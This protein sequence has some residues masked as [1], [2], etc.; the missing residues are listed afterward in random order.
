MST[1]TTAPTVPDMVREAP[2]PAVPVPTP[3]APA[4]A[5][6]APIQ[7][8]PVQVPP[9]R[10]ANA[11]QVQSRAG[12]G[13]FRLPFGLLATVP[14]LAAVLVGFLMD[15][16]VITS[17]IAN[18][19]QGGL[20]DQHVSGLRIMTGASSFSVMTLLI[21]IGPVLALAAL[22][23]GIMTALRMIPL[24][25]VLSI[26]QFVLAVAGIVFMRAVLG[27]AQEQPVEMIK[28]MGLGDI[29]ARILAGMAVTIAPGVGYWVTLAGFGLIALGAIIDVITLS[30]WP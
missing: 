17:P 2:A 13:A 6:P 20:V 15:W 1:D 25:R 22:V 16:L 5:V 19:I 18:F 7:A 8:A 12:T 24:R 4:P 9:Y 3:A 29:A 23:L 28:N 26:A 14:G 21:C 27:I 30:I 11:R 10:P